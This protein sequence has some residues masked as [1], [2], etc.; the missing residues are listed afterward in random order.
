MSN[1][2]S[3]RNFC[4]ISNPAVDIQPACIHTSMATIATVASF[5]PLRMLLRK[6]SKRQKMD[7]NQSRCNRDPVIF[8]NTYH[9]ERNNDGKEQRRKLMNFLCKIT[10]LTHKLTVHGKRRDKK[11]CERMIHER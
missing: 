9:W 8:H 10:S 5:V 3:I 7:L 1:R 2:V 4:N 6:T 11:K